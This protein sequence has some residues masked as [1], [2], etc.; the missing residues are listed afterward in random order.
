MTIIE[1]RKIDWKR[2]NFACHIG[3]RI[4]T[5]IKMIR[6]YADINH[7]YCARN[8]STLDHPNISWA[9]AVFLS[10][11]LRP[12]YPLFAKRKI[13]PSSMVELFSLFCDAFYINAV[14]IQDESEFRNRY[15]NQLNCLDNEIVELFANTMIDLI[16]LEI[17]ITRALSI[18]INSKYD[19]KTSNRGKH[20]LIELLYFSDEMVNFCKK[21]T[22]EL[23][24]SSTALHS[25]LFSGGMGPNE[26]LP[27][28]LGS[29]ERL[30]GVT[31]CDYCT[32]FD[33]SKCFINL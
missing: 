32:T 29:L 5:A 9:H 17:N 4:W 26:N 8:L 31:N 27:Y 18:R 14:N 20:P 1:C 23:I 13:D 12:E 28:R 21:F 24:L 11:L 2:F 3:R 10:S 16:P 22:S 7:V 25:I 30:V 19:Y 15:L 33:L 6:F